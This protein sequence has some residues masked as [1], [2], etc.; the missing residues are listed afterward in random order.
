MKAKP[1]LNIIG[2][3]TRPQPHCYIR[4]CIYDGRHLPFQDKQFDYV[5]LINVLHHADEPAIVLSEAARVAFR[6]IIVK[7]HF[8]NTRL[9]FYTLVAMERIGNAFIDINQPYNFLSE[10][11]WHNLF[12][13]LGLKTEIIRKRFVCYNAII[14]LFFGRNLHFIAKVACPLVRS[15]DRLAS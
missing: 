4:Q 11:Q 13:A 8:A 15:V 1:G 5:L 3:E 9:D 14:D 6:G 10:K 12:Q 7:D 2:A